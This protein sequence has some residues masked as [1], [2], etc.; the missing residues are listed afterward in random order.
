MAHTTDDRSPALVAVTGGGLEI[1]AVGDG[2]PGPPGDRPPSSGP[3]DRAYAGLMRVRQLLDLS[4]FTWSYLVVDDAS[5]EAVL[6]DPVY[7]QHLRDAA[8][9]RELGVHLVLTVDTHCH[10]D[11]VTGAWLMAQAL[12]SRIALAAAYGA[13]NVDVA[14]ADGATIRFGASALEVRATPGHTDG[15]LT[16][17][18][19]E[20]ELAFTGDCLMIR[21]AGR[22]DFQHGSARRMYRSI[23]DRIFT[24]PD[25][26]LVYPAHDY[27]G[28]TA[29]TV[30]EE[31]RFN[32]RIGGDAREEDFVGYMENLGLP[33]PKK[34]DLAVPANL[35]CGRPA[36]GVYPYRV[37]WGPVVATYAGLWEIDA[38]WVARNRHAVHIVDVRAA[39]ELEG[40]LGHITGVQHI[41][42]DELRARAGQV[43]RD[44]PVVTVCQSGKR[45]GMATVILRGAGVDKVANLSGGMLRWRQLGLA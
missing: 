34:M 9:I 28:R 20:P 22:T 43:P 24:L 15:C 45:S 23:V 11:H 14:L 2:L 27:D 4:S 21:S 31:R 7:E 18:G 26:C 12:G 29:S 32:P 25:A 35:R 30:G 39:A 42:L 5:G 19:T 44:R 6:V 1:G 33:H 13:E 38:D 17:V 10:A 8:L 37:D 40:E 3:P 41:P 36:D 16:L